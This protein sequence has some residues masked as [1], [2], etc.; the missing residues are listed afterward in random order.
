MQIGQWVVLEISVSRNSPGVQPYD[1]VDG[2]L[3]RSYY[4]KRVFGL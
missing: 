4:E 3:R 1:T 2:S